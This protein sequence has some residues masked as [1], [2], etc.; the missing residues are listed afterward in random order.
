MAIRTLHRDV[1]DRGRDSRGVDPVG[2]AARI[3]VE[4]G[5][6][7][8]AEDGVRGGEAHVD[9][10]PVIGI[11]A[12]PHAPA[13]LPVDEHEGAVGHQ[14]LGADPVVAMRGDRPRVHRI[15]GVIGAEIEE[16]R[17][18]AAE[19][20][21]QGR[22][23]R[24]PS[25]HGREIGGFA[26]MEGGRAGDR[27][28]HLGGH[29]PG[30]RREDAPPGEDEVARHHRVSVGPPRRPEMKGEGEAVGRGLGAVGDPRAGG[31]G[32]RIPAQ[33]TLRRAR[34]RSADPAV[35]S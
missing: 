19:G 1:P 26:A 29:R 5:G 10:I 20:H 22:V 9:G 33:K 14:M 8:L 28:E 6:R 25:A 17:R 7:M 23:I 18:R 13:E 24:G 34:A 12:E 3:E 31:E 15:V 21:D 32:D 35:R 11:L 2:V 16:V 27:I 4:G 30:L